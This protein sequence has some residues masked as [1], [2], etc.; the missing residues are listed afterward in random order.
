MVD[1]SRQSMIVKGDPR[2]WRLLV[3]GAGGIGSNAAYVAACMG[4]EQITVYEPD[5]VEE[6]N[7]G[8]QWYSRQQV[9]LHKAIALYNAVLDWTGEEIEYY[10]ERY[11]NQKGEFDIVLVGVDALSIRK[12]IWN[13]NRLKWKWWLDGR[14]GGTACSVHAIPNTPEA[15]AAYEKTLQGGDRNLPCGMKAT[16]YITKGVLQGMIG[17]CL[18]KI[19]DQEPVPYLQIWDTTTVFGSVMWEIA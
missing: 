17:T 8:P 2:R 16:A 11:T 9:G 10:A 3:I 15:R 7:I 13:Q 12:R 14:M 1:L 4:I 18:H 19:I 6:G 5:I